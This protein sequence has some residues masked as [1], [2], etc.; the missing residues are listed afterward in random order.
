MAVAMMLWSMSSSFSCSYTPR[1]G[2]LSTCNQYNIAKYY[3]TGKQ[4]IKDRR[5]EEPPHHPKTQLFKRSKTAGSSPVSL[6][7]FAAPNKFSTMRTE[8][9]KLSVEPTPA[10]P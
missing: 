2:S 9:P 10:S 4:T 1:Y 6:S 7:E 3:R 8:S 5:R